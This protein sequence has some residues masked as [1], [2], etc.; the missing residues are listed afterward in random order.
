MDRNPPRSIRYKDFIERF[1]G[2]GEAW[3]TLHR[4]EAEGPLDEKALRLAK[5]G[6]AIGSHREGAVRTAVRKALRAGI[7]RAS[8]EQVVA[9]SVSTVGL[10][11]AA[12]VWTW[13]QD[14]LDEA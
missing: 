11:S 1:P 12:A 13:I 9:L 4:Q 14:L 5:L 6:V 10:P 8:I 3:E 2:V 7:D